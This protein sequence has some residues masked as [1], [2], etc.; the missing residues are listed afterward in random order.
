MVSDDVCRCTLV[1]ANGI[2][3]VKK[4]YIDYQD[5]YEIL[6]LSKSVLKVLLLPI[7][8]LL[9]DVVP[10]NGQ[11]SLEDACSLEVSFIF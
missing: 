7:S 11:L 6:E 3:L 8:E 9:E 2:K 5:N 4:I 1:N 10:Q